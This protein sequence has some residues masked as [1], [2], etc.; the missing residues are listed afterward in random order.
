MF[1]RIHILLVAVFLFTLMSGAVHHHDDGLAQH[2]DCATCITVA[3][4]TAL[5]SDASVELRVFVEYILPL[6]VENEAV[7]YSLVLRSSSPRAPPIV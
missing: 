3:H 6:S 7:V 1:K 4:S 5:T 2:K